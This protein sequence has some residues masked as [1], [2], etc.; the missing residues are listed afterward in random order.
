[1]WFVDIPREICPK[2]ILPWYHEYFDIKITSRAKTHRKKTP[3]DRS[4]I[5][6]TNEDIEKLKHESEKQYSSLRRIKIQPSEEALI[7]DKNTLRKI[8]ELAHK[9]NAII[10]LEGGVLSHAYYQLMQTNAV[11]EII[12]PFKDP[13]DKQEFH[14][15][16]RDKVPSNIK[17]G[18]EVAFEARISGESFLRA[19][20]EKL[21]EEAIEVMDASDQDSIIGE[22]ADLCEIIDEIIS[23]LNVSRDELERRKEQKRKKTGGFKNGIVLLETENPLPTEK[24]SELKRDLFEDFYKNCK[25]SQSIAFGAQKIIEASRTIEKWSD[26]REHPAATEMILHLNIPIVRDQWTANTPE[27]SLDDKRKNVIQA[28]ISGIRKG[29]KLIIELSIFSPHRDRN[30]LELFKTED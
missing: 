14:K 17:R 13:E 21:V 2:P 5:V 16:V 15:L 4:L 28:K 23:Q 8:G 9:I 7:R 30:Q 12:H 27:T 11:V 6:K 24:A 18:G 20:R 25:E 19:L 26:Q 1:M 22:I 3:F 29:S 10:L